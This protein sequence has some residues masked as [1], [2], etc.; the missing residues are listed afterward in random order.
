MKR[1]LIIGAN[2]FTGRRVLEMMASKGLYELYGLSLSNDIFPSKGY[3]FINAD[4]TNFEAIKELFEKIKPNVVINCAAISVPDFCDKN[5][6][7]ADLVNFHS[8]CNLSDLCNETESRFIQLS[9]DF[10]FD[11]EKRSPYNEDDLPNP[12]NYYGQT[13]LMAENYIVNSCNNFAIA[14]VIVVYGKRYAGQHGNI[15]Q[16][17]YDRLISKQ[18]ITVVN[19]QWRSPL[20]VDDAARGIESLAESNKNGI[21]HLSGNDIVSISEI[22]YLVADIM[23]LDS[24]LINSVSTLEMKEV[25]KRPSYSALNNDKIKNE[26]FFSPTS[27]VQGILLS[28]RG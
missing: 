4:I 13:K 17:V 19:D 26:Y 15:I 25:I 21:F 3:H 11:G 14:R 10:V 16:L 24:N 12:V 7:I 1:V 5:R 8:V 22:A 18:P 27:L 6:E 28:L 23:K 2:G 9:T 20:F